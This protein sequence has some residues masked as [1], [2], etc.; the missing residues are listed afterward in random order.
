MKKLVREQGINI[1]AALPRFRKNLMFKPIRPKLFKRWRALSTGLITIQRISIRKTNCAIQ[2]IVIYAMD[3]GIHHLNNWGQKC[4]RDNSKVG[5]FLHSN[6]F[7]AFGSFLLSGPL[8]KWFALYIVYIF[9]YL[10]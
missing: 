4:S 8:L 10:P 1:H 9:I 2:W 3:S 5:T 7:I 6:E